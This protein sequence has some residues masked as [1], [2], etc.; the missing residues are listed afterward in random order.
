MDILSI[1]KPKI[2]IN[3]TFQKNLRIKLLT[4]KNAKKNS[5]F[6]SNSLFLFV[7]AL[8]IAAACFILTFGYF[9][10]FFP[11]TIEP[12]I[13][14]AQKESIPITPPSIS[15]SISEKI[16]PQDIQKI[17]KEK[18]AIDKEMSSIIDDINSI[19]IVPTD[20]SE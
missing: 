16:P 5:Y 8:S 12:K 20:V 17:R 6:S 3:R 1:Y 11:K 18:D 13:R 4:Q 10:I 14:K 15:E 9:D 7:K 2:T 19:K